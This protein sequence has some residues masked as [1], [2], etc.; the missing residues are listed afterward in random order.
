M[1]T[2]SNNDFKVLD[3]ARIEAWPPDVRKELQK[4]RECQEVLEYCIIET[5]REVK[6]MQ[7]NL[8]C[9]HEE[10]I[11]CEAIKHWSP[12]LGKS[13]HGLRCSR[14]IDYPPKGDKKSVTKQWAMAWVE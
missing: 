8:S 6:V 9:C 12:R 5:R 3:T 1:V 13:G 10:G 14:R 7:C 4:S 11:G 2:Q